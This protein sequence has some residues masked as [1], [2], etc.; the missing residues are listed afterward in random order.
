MG[1]LDSNFER[2]LCDSITIKK[3]LEDNEIW[4]RPPGSRGLAFVDL[5]PMN[6]DDLSINN[7][8]L[9]CP[10]GT[11]VSGEVAWK[12]YGITEIDC[13]GLITFNRSNDMPAL[14]RIKAFD[15]ISFEHNF[16]E[17]KD[18]ELN[19]PVINFRGL[20]CHSGLVHD[21]TFNCEEL[22]FADMPKAFHN[23]GGHVGTMRLHV[24][25]VTD[26][27]TFGPCV[28]PKNIE[29]VKFIRNLAGVRA[30]YNNAKKYNAYWAHP[31]ELVDAEAII[32]N[33]EL[34]DMLNGYLYIKECNFE[35]VLYKLSGEWFCT[36]CH[37][38]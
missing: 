3:L 9:R 16:H 23:V 8:V 21:C 28:K 4:T 24:M 27:E 20:A 12:R 33:I 32:R 26:I 13:A 36:E 25:S 7:G 5:D 15:R 6:P 1:I 30:F 19:A 18:I 38:R 37:K 10:S 11:V 22:T 34:G 17:C 29:G 2:Q 31:S 35:I 14:S